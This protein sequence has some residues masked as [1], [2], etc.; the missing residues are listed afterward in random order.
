M[1][2]THVVPRSIVAHLALLA[3]VSLGALAAPQSSHAALTC[4]GKTATVV[5]QPGQTYI[6]GTN[7]HDVI[8]GN[9]QA[10]IIHG[11]DGD[12]TICGGGG[13]DFIYGGRGVD[14]IAGQLGDDNLYGGYHT[15]ALFGNDGNDRVYG[16]GRNTQYGADIPPSEGS[17]DMLYGYGGNDYLE[18]NQNYSSLNGGDGT[19]TC[20]PVAGL[21]VVRCER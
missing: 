5:A 19:D 13:N 4:D 20:R 8:V 6:F 7:G 14:W 1:R 15:D 3:A 10:N 2:L 21:R 9:D 18:D 17:F 16:D 11:Y 12:D